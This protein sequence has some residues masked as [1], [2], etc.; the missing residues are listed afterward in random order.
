MLKSWIGLTDEEKEQ[1]L[2]DNMLSYALEGDKPYIGYGKMMAGC[3]PELL[4]S[5]AQYKEAQLKHLLGAP[6]NV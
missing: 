4:L 3:D 5:L 2:A 6:V 1:D